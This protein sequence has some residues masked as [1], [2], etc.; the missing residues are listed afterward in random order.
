MKKKIIS[1][2][3]AICMLLPC[4]FALTA[5]GDDTPPTLSVWEKTWTYQ[6]VF[7]GNWKTSGGSADSNGNPTGSTVETLLKR[8]FNNFDLKNA[9]IVNSGGEQILDLSSATSA[10]ILKSEIENKA[11]AFFENELKDFSVTFS[12]K[13]EKKLFVGNKTYMAKGNEYSTTSY[14]I[15]AID[16]EQNR[17]GYFNEETYNIPSA[18]QVLSFNI[19]TKKFEFTLCL[20]TKTIVNDD[21]MGKDY[22]GNNGELIRTM[23]NVRFT[24]LLSVQ[25]A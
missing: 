9:K 23:L 13:E 16:D 15:F 21:T 19:N 6:N 4:M 10:D 2:I 5:C 18:N 22:D 25:N 17:L 20:P 8:E 24:A 1:L 12:T 3:F 11:K 14:E 7:D